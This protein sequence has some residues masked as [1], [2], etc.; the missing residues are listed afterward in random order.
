M[1]VMFKD[2]NKSLDR[3][4]YKEKLF[5][6]LKN[7]CAVLI[8]KIAKEFNFLYTNFKYFLYFEFP[9]NNDSIIIGYESC[10]LV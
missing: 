10:L 1:I 9:K 6:Y 2:C 7:R 5:V 4:S 3:G 8:K